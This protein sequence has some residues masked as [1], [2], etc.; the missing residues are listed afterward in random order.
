VPKCCDGLRFI[1]SSSE[2]SLIS[3]EMRMENFYRHWSIQGGMKTEI[4]LGHPAVSYQF[5]DFH[6]R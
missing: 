2:K 5:L 3:S 4:D 1:S 6:F